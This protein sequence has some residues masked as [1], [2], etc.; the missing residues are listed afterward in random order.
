MKKC[1]C[2]FQLKGE[3]LAIE[4]NW[5]L[6]AKD[7]RHNHKISAY[8]YAH[9]QATRLTDDQ[10]KLTE[11]FIRCQIAPQNIMA[12]LLEKNPDCAISK[13]TIYNAR[14]RMKKKRMEEHNTVEEYNIPLVEAI[15]MISTRK[16]FAIAIAFIQN[17]KAETYE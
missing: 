5:K 6:Y 7:G 11:E 12:S 17:E 16:T 1:D 3:K 4:D 14:A 8:P 10:L 13:Q 9:A 15:G 2:I